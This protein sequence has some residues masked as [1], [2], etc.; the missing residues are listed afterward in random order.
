MR[1]N[2]QEFD[3]RSS[4][5]HFLRVRSPNATTSSEAHIRL[6]L[7]SPKAIAQYEANRLFAQ[8]FVY[9]ELARLDVPSEDRALKR[10]LVS[11]F[12]RFL[13]HDFNATAHIVTG[14][15]KD[16]SAPH[17]VIERFEGVHD[18]SE[19][20]LLKYQRV[21]LDDHSEIALCVLVL[22]VFWELAPW[23]LLNTLKHFQPSIVLMN[24]IAGERQP[25]W[26][27]QRCANRAKVCEDGSGH[28][29]PQA[30]SLTDEATE[31]CAEH[32]RDSES[33]KLRLQWDAVARAAQHHLEAMKDQREGVFNLSD[34]LQG[35]LPMTEYRES[36]AY[37]C[38]ALTYFCNYAMVH[39][40]EELEFFAQSSQ[41][42]SFKLEGEWAHVARG[43]LHWPS[44]LRGKHIECASAL[45]RTIIQAELSK[46]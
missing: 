18:P 14:L 38:N 5:R 34:I 4:D 31:L 6:Q 20:T 2:L 10:V 25:L 28:L 1:P 27:E 42:L 40:Q 11:G 3:V 30:L 29:V 46:G 45:L 12:G 7:H 44:E 33:E 9:R 32:K 19:Q 17:A 8:E 26:L 41:P 21:S 16:V 43:F 37:L 22:P 35:I 39:P 23:L 13:T 15:L 36:N 24:G